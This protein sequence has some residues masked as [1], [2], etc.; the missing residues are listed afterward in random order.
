MQNWEI[1]L[2]FTVITILGKLF[3]TS[4]GTFLSGQ[5]LT[6]SLRV[7]FSMAQIGEFS[8]IIIGLGFVLHAIDEKL[9]PIIVAVAGITTFTTPYLIR[10]SDYVAKQLDMNLPDKMKH[11]LS[12]YSATIYKMQSNTKQKSILASILLCLVPNVII[13]AIIFKLSDAFVFSQASPKPWWTEIVGWIV[14]MTLSSP[15][16]WGMLFSFKNMTVAYSKK[17]VAIIHMFICSV[18]LM[19]III[20]SVAYFETWLTAILLSVITLLFFGLMHDKLGKTYHWLEHHFVKN[21]KQENTKDNYEQLAPWDTHLIDITIDDTSPLINRTLRQCQIRQKFGINV[22][23][24]Y[25]GTTV[26]AAPRGDE[27]LLAHD[28]LIVLG[29][30]EQL[31]AF[32]PLAET[33]MQTE[34][35]NYLDDFGL[36]TILLENHHH[37]IGKTIRESGIREKVSGLI[38]GLEHHG[39][40]I[41]NPDPNTTLHAGDLVVIV[42][43]LS[44][45]ET[46]Q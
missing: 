17:A 46:M 14:A 33:Q 2:L 37:F 42:G 21:L 23:A 34:E 1:V 27:I 8:F 13:V 19:E 22:V 41:L 43:K 6:T 18:V 16:L 25:R 10:Y 3:S 29:N 5:S 35:K 30:D 38:V 24:I 44:D 15:F 45:L 39:R 11:T 9:Y 32:R 40:Q 20:L 28:K 31:D 7:G 12:Q 36:K 26:L 4:L